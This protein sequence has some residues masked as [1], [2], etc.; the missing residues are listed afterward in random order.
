MDDM[1]DYLAQL[2]IDSGEGD[3][4]PVDHA[5]GEQSPI[6]PSEGIKRPRVQ[7]HLS[8]VSTA[9]DSLDSFD[10]SS[11][12]LAQQTLEEDCGKLIEEFWAAENDTVPQKLARIDVV[13]KRWC[14]DK[15]LKS[16]QYSDSL[17]AKLS[18]LVDVDPDD[19]KLAEC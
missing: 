17:K 6:V 14:R 3:A 1:E 10:H 18:E 12:G 13:L 9:A 16:K 4:I 8:G 2:T 19:D 7:P 15:K 5:I 11:A